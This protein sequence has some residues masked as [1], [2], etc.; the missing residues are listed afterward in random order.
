MSGLGVIV[1]HGLGGTPHSVLPITAAV[2]EA[3][4]QTVAP[5]LPGH[6]TSP[7]DLIG[8]RWDDWLDA[9]GAATDALSRRT[10]GVALIGQSLGGTLALAA[11]ARRAD[12]RGV[13]AI[14]ALATAPD[15]DATEHLEHLI[16]RGKTMQPAGDADIR[17]PAA[18]D[19]AYA[20]LAL[21]ALV[22][23][24]AGAAAVHDALERIT[25]PTFVAVSAHD[26]VVDPANADVI[27]A[28][29]RGPVSRL[30]LPNSAHVAALDLD[31]HLL[32]TELLTWLTSL[33][34][35]SAAPV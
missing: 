22:Q 35:G 4:Y 31:R 20:E 11:A 32:C 30:L 8:V 33:T 16:S 5:R 1:L 28:G 3:G 14:N 13:A 19:S 7:E 25:V 24:G 12:V 18:H 34:D 2:H 6:G 27:A 26:G 15:S 9:V 10:S 17:D 23:L 29:V 21:N